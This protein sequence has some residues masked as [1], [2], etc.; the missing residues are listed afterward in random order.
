MSYRF[1]WALAFHFALLLLGLG[2]TLLVRANNNWS[3]AQTVPIPSAGF[4]LGNFSGVAVALDNATLEPGEYIANPIFQKSVWYTFTIATTRQVSISMAL[5]GL[6]VSSTSLG[7]YVYRETAGIPSSSDLGF[8]TDGA[9]GATSTNECL[10][11]GKYYIQ[12]C[13]SLS[14]SINVNPQLEISPTPSADLNDNIASPD[15]AGVITAGNQIVLDW[16]CLSLQTDEE[17]FPSLGADYLNYSKSYWVTFQTDG[18]IDLFSYS[19]ELFAGGSYTD[20]VAVRIFEAPLTLANF[21]PSNAIYSD[22]R[23]FHYP[24]EYTHIPC[25][26]EANTTYVMQI[27]GRRDYSNTSYVYLKHLGEGE[28]AEPVPTEAAW[29]AGNNFGTVTSTPMPGTSISLFDYFSCPSQMS[30]ALP[31]CNNVIPSTGYTGINNVTYDLTNWFTLNLTQESSLIVTSSTVCQACPNNIYNHSMYLRVFTQAPNNN[32]NSFQL[33]ADVF[34]EGPFN[35]SGLCYVTCLPAGEYTLQ[36]MGR[37]LLSSNPYDC[38]SSQFG[39]RHDITVAFVEPAI[40]EYGMAAAGDVDEINNGNALQDNV[41]YTADQAELTCEQTVLPDEVVCWPT[42]DRAVYRTL[43]IG[44]ADNDAVPDSGMLIIRNYNF[45]NFTLD[46]ASN[47][48]FYEGDVNALVQAQGVY[49]W[50]DVVTGL[51][52]LMD[53]GLFNQRFYG[54]YWWETYP[55]LF[56]MHKYC[57]TPGTYTLAQYGDSSDVGA[58]LQPTFEFKKDVTQFWNPAAPDN[59]GDLLATGLMHLSQ[60]DTFSCLENPATIDG[61]APC[62]RT[63][64][65]YREFYLSQEAEIIISEAPNPLG[66]SFFLEGQPAPIL[67]FSGQVSQV[68]IEG[69]SIVMDEPEYCNSV[70]T[71]WECESLPPGW[72]TV[73]SYGFGPGYENN[74]EFHE[75]NLHA[76]YHGCGADTNGLYSMN[77]ISQISIQLDTTSAPGPFYYKPGI[78]CVAPNTISYTNVLTPDFPS[79]FTEYVLCSEY[80]ED[81]TYQSVVNDEI[82]VC[83]NDP[84]LDKVAYYVFTTDDEYFLRIRNL[85]VFRTLLYDLDVTTNDSLQLSTA[86]PIVPCQVGFNDIE[87]CSLPAGTY[88][89]LVFADTTKDC[90]NAT[91]IIDVSPVNYSRFDFADQAYDFDL[92]PPDGVFHNG[93]VGD[94]HPTNPNLSPSNDFFYCTT[95][96]FPSDPV[97]GCVGT[98]TDSIYN[99]V[100]EPVYYTDEP[101]L[102]QEILRR[103]LWYTFVVQGNGTATIEVRNLSSDAY[104]N[105]FH[106]YS[107]NLS[108]EIPWSTITSSNPTLIDSTLTDSLVLMVHNVHWDNCGRAGAIDLN[109]QG[110]P[111]DSLTKRRFYIIVDRFHP[112]DYDYPY[113]LFEALNGQIDVRIRWNRLPVVEYPGDECSDAVATQSSSSGIFPVCTIIDCHTNVDPFWDLPENIDCMEGPGGRSSTW[114]KFNYNGPDVVD[115][116]FQ[117]DISGLAN[118]GLPGDID[119]RVFYGNS[120][121]TLIAGTECAQSSYISNTIAC[122]DSTTGDFYVEVSYPEDAT[123]TLCFNFSVA[124][125]TNPNC[126]PFNPSAVE[127]FFQYNQVCTLDTV[128]FMNYSTVGQQMEYTWDFGHDNAM[129]NLYSP[130]HIFP[131][132]GDYLVTLTATNSFAGSSD[133][134]SEVIHVVDSTDL[135]LLVG[136]TMICYGD[137]LTLGRDLFQATY[138]WSTGATTSTIEVFQPGLYSVDYTVIGCPFQDETL[139][140]VFQLIPPIPDS[141]AICEYSTL[142]V[143]FAPL[144]SITWVDSPSQIL[145]TGAV[146]YTIFPDS[147][148]LLPWIAF[149]QG[150][151][152]EGELEV[153]E[154]YAFVPD[155]PSWDSI[156]CENFNGVALPDFPANT[157]GLFQFDNADV[158]V[159]NGAEFMPGDYSMNYIYTDSIGCPDTLRVP[160]SVLDTLAI[161]WITPEIV[162]CNDADTVMLY[163]M[164]ED[165]TGQFYISY[166]PNQQ[167]SFASD[168]FIPGLA[169]GDESVPNTYG[170]LYEVL[171]N[172]EC[173]SRSFGEIILHPDPI[174]DI[175]YGL[176]CEYA[177]LHLE[178]NT[179]VNGGNV[180]SYLWQFETGEI[181]NIS[182]PVFVDLDESGYFSFELEATSNFGC[183]AVIEDSVWVN[184]TPD[185]HINYSSIC[186][187]DSLVFTSGATVEQGTLVQYAWYTEGQFMGSTPNVSWTFNDAGLFDVGVHVWSDAGC[188]GTDSL[189][190]TIYPTPQLAIDAPSICVGD[191]I[192][193]VLISN[194]PSDDVLLTTWF[195]DGL[196][197]GINVDSISLVPSTLDAVELEVYQYSSVGCEGYASHFVEVFELPTLEVLPT[198]LDYCL[199]DTVAIGCVPSVQSPQNVQSTQWAFSNGLTFNSPSTSFIASSPG[200]FDAAVNVTTNFGCVNSFEVDNYVI[201]HPDPIAN[202]IL[203]NET[204]TYYEDEVDIINQSSSNVVEWNYVISDGF[205]ADVPNFSHRFYESGS[206]SIR[207]AVRDVHGCV[208][209]TYKSLEFSPELIVHIPNSFTPDADGIN[210]VFVPVIDGDPLTYYRLIVF[211]RWGTIIFESLDRNKVWQGDVRENGYYAMCDAYNYML[212]VKTVRGY[213]K[214]YMGA[215]LLL[216]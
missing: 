119:Y 76:G 82:F 75:Q 61:I 187:F 134:Y 52:P 35:G 81:S 123:G 146:Q 183:N 87:I 142:E 207:L 177:Y 156:F 126:I 94:V 11:A 96:A 66:D 62:G 154:L 88:S 29:S 36:I 54:C 135:M 84:P 2:N 58:V 122:V 5:S 175:E 132:T 129:S 106:V 215:I 24:G 12:I 197:N 188:E 166:L 133:V 181:Q 13:G 56:N 161:G 199:G 128:Y 158:S 34:Y 169:L 28:T 155:I 111:C 78:A 99:V 57:V 65:I 141:V 157:S 216:R 118:Y 171:H 109:V 42:I 208:D 190:V 186:Q 68:G 151:F 47:S 136:D 140:D 172:E 184:P 130:F 168:Y 204:P 95:G 100:N 39:R 64:L 194:A 21:N 201:V 174:F 40:F 127:A 152:V 18:H 182:Q 89:L 206:Y 210:D 198:D 14:L 44:D 67:F 4:G 70:F 139:L 213:E 104:A 93:R 138:S 160:F 19:V 26:L 51:D 43:E 113:E 170:V 9:V 167:A 108:G 55:R 110:D 205:M 17:Y 73:V 30:E 125:N 90:I 203:S 114:Y 173:T 85:D 163:S 48:A 116:G 98:Y 23:G 192:Q 112:R 46:I 196:P 193:A 32:C 137:T 33:P 97:I 101:L 150:C 179:F 86:I 59:M 211:D 162:T 176:Q 25:L 164:V 189:H 131:G 91:P 20:Q 105:T 185:A 31:V 200:T 115:I 180:T 74:Y 195:V 209:T 45:Q 165:T 63:K 102:E 121:P 148:L 10:T 144:D 71:R 6:D 22:S 49:D 8:F 124:L 143:D 191:T 92:V 7:F 1:K 16:P 50:P 147:I 145:E 149:D 120:C 72:Y 60:P 37:S 202:F 117:P 178:N 153:I 27:I 214:T 159:L 69:L 53:C 41:L 3:A 103:N 80:F 212:E 83:E 107:T 79:P 77:Y 38:V 15:N